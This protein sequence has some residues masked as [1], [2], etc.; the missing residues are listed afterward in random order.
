MQIYAINI[1]N[2]VKPGAKQ[3]TSQGA[4]ALHFLVSQCQKL[5]WMEGTEQSGHG[6]GV[7]QTHTL[8]CREDLGIAA[9]SGQG[10]KHLV[11]LAQLWVRLPFIK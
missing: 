6:L 2:E 1:T 3:R 7:P 8:F 11:G 9:F 5:L 4:S 10:Q